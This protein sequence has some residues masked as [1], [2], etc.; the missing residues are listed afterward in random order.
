MDRYNFNIV[1]KKWQDFWDKNQTF[2]T[3]KIKDKKKILC[4]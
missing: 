2:K 3:T 4:T 1:E